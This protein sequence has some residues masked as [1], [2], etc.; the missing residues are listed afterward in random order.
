[1]RR[2]QVLFVKAVETDADIRNG[3][4]FAKKPYLHSQGSIPL[5]EAVALDETKLG[6]EGKADGFGNECQGHCGVQILIA[7]AA[8]GSSLILVTAW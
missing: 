4:A 8:Q 3:L 1:M 6:T 7:C 5:A 2:W